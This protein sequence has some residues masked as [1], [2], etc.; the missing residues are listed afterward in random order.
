VDDY[1]HWHWSMAKAAGLTLMLVE[2]SEM[3]SAQATQTLA[4]L[5]QQRRK[6]PAL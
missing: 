6:H 5:K 1:G 4:L 2:L 3:N